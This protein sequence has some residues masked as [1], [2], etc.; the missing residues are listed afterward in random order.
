MSIAPHSGVGGCAPR[1]RNDR[2]AAVMMEVPI[3]MVKYTTIDERVPGKICR[4]MMVQSEAPML[5][6][7][8]I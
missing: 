2:L 8:S 6:A 4:T 3:R 5:R 1:P 7:D